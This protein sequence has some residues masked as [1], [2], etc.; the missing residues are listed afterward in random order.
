VRERNEGGSGRERERDRWGRVGVIRDLTLD[1]RRGKRSTH[2][3]R[4]C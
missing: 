4:T 3:P 1:D 2:G